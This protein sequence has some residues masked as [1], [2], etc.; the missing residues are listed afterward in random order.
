MKAYFEEKAAALF[1]RRDV[2]RV[3]ISADN[4]D[5]DPD[6]APPPILSDSLIRSS[7]DEAEPPEPSS[8]GRLPHS[9]FA[10]ENPLGT[11]VPS[12]EDLLREYESSKI[13]KQ[14]N[15]NYMMRVNDELQKRPFSFQIFLK[16]RLETLDRLEVA[17]DRSLSDQVTTVAQRLIE[18]RLAKLRSKRPAT[19]DTKS[20][21]NSVRTSDSQKTSSLKYEDPLAR[22]LLGTWKSSASSTPNASFHDRLGEAC[23]PWL[24]RFEFQTLSTQPKVT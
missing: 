15:C 7:E 20:P 6:V 1:M 18:R 10:S 22:P 4:R 21:L 14:V 5:R 12:Q 11:S 3:F 13:G 9:L 24:A 2:L 8:A 17:A 19:P 23:W 16:E